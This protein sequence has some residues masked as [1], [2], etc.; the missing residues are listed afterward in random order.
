[1]S[2]VS[3]APCGVLVPHSQFEETEEFLF[4]AQKKEGRKHFPALNHLMSECT[5]ISP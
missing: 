4:L 3:L 2:T 1:M 5:G